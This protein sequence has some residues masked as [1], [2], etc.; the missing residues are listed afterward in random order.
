MYYVM[1]YE[2]T[3]DKHTLGIMCV[4]PQTWQRSVGCVELTYKIHTVS[5]PTKLKNALR[6][7]QLASEILDPF[8]IWPWNPVVNNSCNVESCGKKRHQIGENIECLNV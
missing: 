3:F 7:S 8:D 1:L 5:A 6:S 4:Y 2:Q